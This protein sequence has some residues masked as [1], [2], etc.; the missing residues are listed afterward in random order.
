VASAGRETHSCHRGG[1]L[2]VRC[3]W[4]D[5]CR[6]VAAEVS[7]LIGQRHRS[8]HSAEA[9]LEGERDGV[10]EDER[11]STGSSLATVDGDEIDAPVG[12]GHQ[13]GQ[14]VPELQATDRGLDP[15]RQAG[16]GSEQLDP[17]EQ[18]VSVRELSVTRRADA[19]PTLRD[20]SELKSACTQPPRGSAHHNHR[21]GRVRDDVLA[22]RT[23]EH[24][25]KAPAAVGADHYQVG[26]LGHVDQHLGG[27]SF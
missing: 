8:C 7:P 2:I 12:S 15:D 5:F 16:L 18:T 9:E 14:L 27:A 25:G 23:Q 24:A 6:I 26:P 4:G 10:G 22:Y 21:A 1:C 20:R 13:R 3:L 19:V 17:V 11:R